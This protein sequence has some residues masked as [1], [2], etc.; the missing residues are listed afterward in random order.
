MTIPTLGQLE[1]EIQN[2]IYN[3]EDCEVTIVAFS[4]FDEL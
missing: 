1:K 3:P 4:K 2:S